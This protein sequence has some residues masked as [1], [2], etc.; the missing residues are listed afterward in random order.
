MFQK[1]DESEF[2]EQHINTD[3]V[4]KLIS[5]QFPEYAHYLLDLLESR[6]MIIVH[7]A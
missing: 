6:D 5:E 3:L 1:I 2:S 7:I 4:K